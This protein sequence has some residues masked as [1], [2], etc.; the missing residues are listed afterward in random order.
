MSHRT[1]YAVREEGRVRF[2]TD[3][4]GGTSLPDVL[5]EGEAHVRAWLDEYDAATPDGLYDEA[6]CEGLLLLDL[7]ERVVL[8]DGVSELMFE[9]AYRRIWMPL[10]REIWAGW[11]LLHTPEPVRHLGA[12]LG[13]PAAWC[14]AK[15][16]SDPFALTR[17][18]ILSERDLSFVNDV[19]T[20]V[21]WRAPD[22]PWSW[23]VVDVKP[24]DVLHL[25]PALLDLAPETPAVEQRDRL[26]PWGVLRIDERERRLEVWTDVPLVRLVEE[27]EARWPGWTVVLLSFGEAAAQSR[28]GD[29]FFLTDAQ[30]DRAFV[31]L[32]SRLDSPVHMPFGAAV[33]HVE[34]RSSAG[35]RSMRW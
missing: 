10:L 26:P 4:H 15:A 33:K 13:L 30:A 7:D 29:R 1:N 24:L 34:E 22:G 19:Q 9:G 35:L 16:P 31:D 28:Q 11:Q 5:F 6:V 27:A 23:T 18:T 20:E 3:R 25:G 2:A 17:P 12:Y 14:E 21:Q 8:F 32:R